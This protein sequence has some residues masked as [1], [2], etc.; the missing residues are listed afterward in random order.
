MA[1][2]DFDRILAF[3]GTFAR[4]VNVAHWGPIEGAFRRDITSFNWRSRGVLD[5]LGV[6]H[7]TYPAKARIPGRVMFGCDA[8][9]A[10]EATVCEEFLAR[11]GTMIVDGKA[12]LDVLEIEA[13][14]HEMEGSGALRV[15]GPGVAGHQPLFWFDEKTTSIHVA[16]SEALVSGQQGPLVSRIAHGGGTIVVFSSSVSSY[17]RSSPAKETISARGMA[18]E[19]AIEPPTSGDIDRQF[20]R[21]LFLAQVTMMSVF[22]D[23]IARAL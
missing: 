3:A 10:P 1:D 4:R 6:L 9:D 14:A 22:G 13:T 7:R 11:G 16:D 19:L 8:K 12:L 17:S 15:E 20:P 21:D 5:A 23:V 18:K 2:S